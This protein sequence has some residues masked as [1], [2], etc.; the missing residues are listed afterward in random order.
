MAKK[1]SRYKEEWIL[2]FGL[3]I[4]SYDSEANEVTSLTCRF[5]EFGRNSS[6]IDSHRQRKRAK[7]STYYKRPWRTDNMLRHLKQQHSVY[8]EQYTKLTDIEKIT[9]FNTLIQD[10]SAIRTTSAD[11]AE[12]TTINTRLLQTTQKATTQVQIDDL[13]VI[14]S[15]KR[16]KQCKQF[17]KVGLSIEKTQK[18]NND[19]H[20]LVMDSTFKE[21]SSNYVPPT[22]SRT[23]VAEESM[24][25]FLGKLCDVLCEMREMI[26]YSTHVNRDLYLLLREQ[27]STLKRRFQE[28]DVQK[29]NG[30]EIVRQK[31]CCGMRYQS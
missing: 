10:R 29:Y 12:E 23:T 6:P 18:R 19:A 26:Q 24:N 4:M 27:Q 2:R 11:R 20:N 17:E 7:K 21:N 25:P 5:C 14:A 15:G 30:V 3:K 31:D 13:R 9:F 1:E 8:F 28:A 16:Y 22:K